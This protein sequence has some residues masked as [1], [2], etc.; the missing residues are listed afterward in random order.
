[1]GTSR[2]WSY[3]VVRRSPR[4]LRR[5]QTSGVRRPWATPSPHSGSVIQA[6][7]RRETVSR[8]SQQKSENAGRLLGHAVGGEE[9]LSQAHSMLEPG[10]R[11]VLRTPTLVPLNPGGAGVLRKAAA[12]LFLQPNG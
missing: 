4:G 7:V 12:D 3:R 9:K 8:G 10:P 6:Q 1:M 2:G 5:G 11:R